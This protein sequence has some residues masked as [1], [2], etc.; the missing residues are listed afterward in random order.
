MLDPTP[1]WYVLR[2]RSR[3]EKKAALLLAEAGF[4]TFL[5]LSREIH[6]WKD[7]NKEVLIPLLSGI[8]LVKC[9]AMKLRNALLIPGVSRIHSH[10][11]KP[12]TLSD[13]QVAMVRLSLLGE[14]KE[15]S[16]LLLYSII[17][18]L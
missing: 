18:P 4:E 6:R 2:T 17:S 12:V 13:E 14:T 16:T 5:P 1:C 9:P 3:C 15:E 7:R 11:Q 10:S 8:V